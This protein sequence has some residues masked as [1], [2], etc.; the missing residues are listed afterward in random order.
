MVDGSGTTT[1]IYDNQDRLVRKETPQGALT[2]TYDAAG[3]LAS[4]Q[5]SNL[6]G[7]SVSYAYD[8]MNRLATVIDNRLPAG[9]NTST[10]VYDSASNLATI[11]YPNQVQQ[12]LTY[13][14]VNRLT[15]SSGCANIRLYP[16]R[17]R[18]NTIS[19]GDIRSTRI[20]R[21]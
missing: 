11:T 21:L 2:Y 6:N 13:D 10:Y 20:V 9:H 14:T 12:T 18:S 4:M 19:G 17:K 16:K 7:A 8:S 3:N 1:Y 15:N 5:S